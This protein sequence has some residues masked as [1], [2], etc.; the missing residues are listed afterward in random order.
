MTATGTSDFHKLTA[1]SLKSQVLEAPAKCKFYR[2]YKNFDKD[3]CNKDLKLKLDSLEE[4]D[5]SLFGNTFMDV[6][7]THAPT[8]T[9]TLRPNS[10]EFMTK[11][12][13][14]DMTSQE[15]KTKIFLQSQHERSK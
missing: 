15:K 5:Y 11:A 14:K 13:W 12:L 9:K 3:N 8:K 4:L 10:P 6:L 2:D 1:V 7:N